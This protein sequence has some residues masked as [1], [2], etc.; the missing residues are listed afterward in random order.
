MEVNKLYCM[1]NLEL[2]KQ[3][4]NESID[5]IYCDILYN[6]GKK[7][8]DYDDRLGTPQ[9]AIQWYRPRLEEMKRVLKD[10]GSIYLQCDWRLVHYL[11]V[12][13]DIIFKTDNFINEIIW[14]YKAGT[15]KKN[16]LGKN[17]DTILLYSKSSEYI[18][19]DFNMKVENKTKYTKRDLDGR[20]YHVN[21]QGKIYYLD[22]G[23]KSSDV[24]NDIPILNS[25]AKDR[26][27]Y[28]TQ[29]P[30]ALLERII[31]AS[32]NEGDVVADFF[33]GS[34]TTCVVAKELGRKY[35][36]CDINPRAINIAENRISEVV[37]NSGLY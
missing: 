16:S 34:G 27:G 18:F 14:C 9:E 15:K 22:D 28:D 12:E 8:K 17:H 25:M 13:M 29:K 23:R 6:T 20:L 32:S 24:W 31:T 2:L 36:G 10:T 1:D 26:V 4:P 11:K 7:F 21:G 19:N 33:M 3:I 30:K 37:K 35:I 5:L